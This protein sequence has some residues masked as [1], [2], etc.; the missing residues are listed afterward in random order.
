[1]RQERRIEAIEHTLALRD[2]S[3]ADL[4]EYVRQQEFPELRRSVAVEDF[5]IMLADETTRVTG[6]Q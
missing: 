4:E 1:M 5:L 6:Q 3:L 2:V